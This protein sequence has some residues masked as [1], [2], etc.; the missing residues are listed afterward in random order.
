MRI[1]TRYF[2][3]PDDVDIPNR[4]ECG[5]SVVAIVPMPS[6]PALGSP[7]CSVT[8]QSKKKGLGV[9]CADGTLVM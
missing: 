8:G 9:E 7:W 5:S 6:A 4:N 3:V 2:L 1:P